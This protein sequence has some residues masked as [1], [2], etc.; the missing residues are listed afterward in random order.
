MPWRQE[1]LLVHHVIWWWWTVQNSRMMHINNNL[2]P[3]LCC[4]MA[5]L[6]H[7]VLNIKWTS[8][9]DDTK[10]FCFVF[11][12]YRGLLEPISKFRKERIQALADRLATGEFELVLLQEVS[13]II[14]WPMPLGARPPSIENVKKILWRN[15]SILSMTFVMTVPSFSVISLEM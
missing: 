10:L 5:T 12:S 8:H 4:H 3:D 13:N 7:N 15:L 9:L 11:F 1:P 6:G 2:Y 14:K